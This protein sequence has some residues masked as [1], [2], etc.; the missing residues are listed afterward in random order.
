L[1]LPRLPLISLWTVLKRVVSIPNIP[2]KMHLVFPR[3]KRGCN[4]M[5]R[6]ISPPLSGPSVILSLAGGGELGSPRSRS[7]LSILGARK[8]PGMH[9]FARNPSPQSQSYSSLKPCF[10]FSNMASSYIVLTVT[11]IVGIAA[12]VRNKSQRVIRRNELRFFSNEF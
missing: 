1:A 5:D 11:K 7:L 9:H 8:I 2:E 10:S 6:C 12:V 4:T 3:E